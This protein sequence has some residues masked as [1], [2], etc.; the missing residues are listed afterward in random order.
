MFHS[1]VFHDWR[2]RIAVIDFQINNFHFDR[3]NVFKFIRLLETT[4]K[5]FI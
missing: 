2:H 4:W 1:L 5:L 3:K